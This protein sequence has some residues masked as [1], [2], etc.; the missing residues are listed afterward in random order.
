MP[1]MKLLRRGVQLLALFFFIILLFGTTWPLRTPVRPQIFLQADPLAALAVA[2]SPERS[3]A[4]LG[5]FWPALALLGLTLLLGRFFCGWLCPLGACIDIADWAL[6]RRVKKRRP[7]LN[8]PRLKYYLLALVLGAALFGTHLFWILDPIPLLT[9]TFATLIEPAGKAFYNAALFKMDPLLVTLGLRLDPLP[10]HP[11]ALNL[12]VAL[13]F[14]AVLGLSLLSRR[15]WCRSLCPLGALLA[16]LGRFGL[17]RRQVA[18]TCLTCK[19]CTLDCKMGA[20]PEEEPTTTRQAEC[21][22]CYDCLGCCKPACT[23]ISLTFR[24]AGVSPTPTPG[25]RAARATGGLL[26]GLDAATDVDRRRFLGILALGATYGLVAVSGVGR[27]PKQSRLIR[28]PG[29]IVRRPNGEFKRTMTEEE[30]RDKCLRCGQCMKACITGGLQPAVV[31]AGF[32]GFYTPILVPRV[33]WCEQNCAACGQVCPSGA[34]IPFTIAEKKDIQIGL[35][36]IDHSKC[37]AWREGRFYRQ[38]LV[39]NEHCSYGAVKIL[40]FQG[41][42]RPFVDDNTCV[43]CG[44]CEAACPVKPEAA[45]VAYRRG[46]PDET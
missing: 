1:K 7:Q 30:F 46:R 34:L 3:T 43:G 26:G 2:L 35:A 23:S 41:A 37:L 11:F 13:V 32:D 17:W 44:I 14:T 45:I 12:L 10:V 28:P 5:L 42:D 9:R 33:G 40:R 16:F 6:W 21:I 22:Q 29:A 38:C 27:R 36:T 25:G 24:S 19:C 31:E 4:L 20:I 8:R 39:C 15:Y 18:E